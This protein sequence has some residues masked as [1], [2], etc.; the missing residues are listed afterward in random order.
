MQNSSDE[1]F[2]LSRSVVVGGDP[3]SVV[4]APPLARS[5][6]ARR[7]VGLGLLG[8]LRRDWLLLA[9]MLP[10]VLYLLVFVYLPNLGNI[11]A[12]QQYL[13]FLGF[14]SPFVGFENFR[15][16]FAAPAF[17]QAVRNTIVISVM[18]L[19]LYFPAPIL[20]ALLLNS[21]ISTPARRLVQSVVYLPHFISWVIIVALFQQIFGGAG[22]VDHLFRDVG[23]PAPTVTNNPDLFKWLMTLQVIWKE[24]GWG[25]II[26]LAALIA[27]EAEL[28]EAAAVDG[29][30]PWQRMWNI[31][32][33][34]IVGVTILLFILRLGALL[35]AGFEQILLQR[36]A[37]GPDAGEILDTYVYFQGIAAGQYAMAAAA[38]LIKAIVGLV[39]IITA[40][41]VAHLFG[42]SGLI[43]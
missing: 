25:T 41:K 38:G 7:M 8:K 3:S 27:I 33:P 12:F 24:T 19:V 43:S 42:H 11:I 23:L 10:G 32:L 17:W 13:P 2:G 26:Y 34:G 28:Y 20:L 30:G 37:V 21:L 40:N 5:A 39:L 22:L 16:L 29:A 14:N 18:Q 9:M 36:N 6:P 4:V 1:R 15:Q 31:T 35:S